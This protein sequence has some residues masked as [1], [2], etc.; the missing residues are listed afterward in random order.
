MLKV[1]KIIIR[2]VIGKFNLDINIIYFRE[3]KI[4]LINN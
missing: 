2:K 4:E 1:I 3:K